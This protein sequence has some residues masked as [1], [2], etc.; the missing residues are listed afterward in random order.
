[1]PGEGKAPCLREHAVRVVL[2]PAGGPT[3]ETRG[4]EW[5]PSL[6]KGKVL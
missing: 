5:L 2:D 3:V 4:E 1:M 6:G